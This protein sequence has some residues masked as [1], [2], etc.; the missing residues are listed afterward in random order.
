MIVCHCMAIADHDIR[1]AVAWMRASHP[2]TII[3]PGKVYRALGK[4]ADCGGCLPLFLD[5]LRSSDG[6]AVPR[7]AVHAIHPA[8]ARDEHEG[9]SEGHRLSERGAAV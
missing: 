8:S 5:T 7:L 2:A 1:A 9:R 3:T 6:F 4:R